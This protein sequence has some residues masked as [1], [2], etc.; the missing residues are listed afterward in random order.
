MRRCVDRDTVP[1]VFGGRKVI[2]ALLIWLILIGINRQRDDTK[3][4]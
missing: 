3:E 1:V 4:V 2:S